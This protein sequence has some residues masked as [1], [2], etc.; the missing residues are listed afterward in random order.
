LDFD[1]KIIKNLEKEDVPCIFGDMG[2]PEILELL[3]L[4]KAKM[5]ISTVADLHDNLELLEIVGKINPG[6]VTILTASQISEALKLY[7]QG[8]NYVILPHLLGGHIVA[9]LLEK[10]WQDLGKLNESR[11]AHIKEL[12]ERRDL[13]YEG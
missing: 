1:P 4:A 7:Q 5:V 11:A 2:D 6:L 10:H 3:N 8:A 12:L 13:G 9:D